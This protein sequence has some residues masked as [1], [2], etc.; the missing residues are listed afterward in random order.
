MHPRCEMDQFK[1]QSPKP[2][3]EDV[4]ATCDHSVLDN[5]GRLPNQVTSTGKK[6][7]ATAIMD[8]MLW[9]TSMQIMRLCAL[10]VCVCSYSYLSCNCSITRLP[11][12]LRQYCAIL[13]RVRR[14]SISIIKNAK[15]I[16]M[17]LSLS[18]VSVCHRITGPACLL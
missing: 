9:F 15:C 4:R 7:E 17:F 10:T 2:H 11:L 1:M 13:S 14:H 6:Q 3:L 12:K 16:M 8:Y 18:V 5:T